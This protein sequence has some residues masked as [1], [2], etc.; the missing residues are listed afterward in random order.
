MKKILFCSLIIVLVLVNMISCTNSEAEDKTVYRKITVDEAKKMMDTEKV[1]VLDVRNKD[2]YDQGHIKNAILLPNP[3][4]EQRASEVLPDKNAKI[5][6]YCRSGKRSAEASKKLI[7]MGY[8][9][10]YDFGGIMDWKYEIVK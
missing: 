2:E 6:V 9:N 10:I 4:I 8:T 5:L 3:E 1:I 7:D